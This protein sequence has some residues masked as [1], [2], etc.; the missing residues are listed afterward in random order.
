M[1]AG[2]TPV[3]RA[4]LDW[5]PATGPRRAT[6][7]LGHGTATGVEA[8]DLQALA[9]ALPDSGITV[10][11]MTQPYRIEHDRRLSDEQPLDAAWEAI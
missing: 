6:L 1:S 11:L 2:A 9:R 7:V 4:R 10:V 8:G 3:G 5:F